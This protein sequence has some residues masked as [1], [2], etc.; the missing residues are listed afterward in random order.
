MVVLW[1]A[2]NSTP[3]EPYLRCVRARA[4]NLMMPYAAIL[5]VISEFVDQEDE[6]HIISHPD[7][8]TSF[9]EL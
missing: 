7:M 4:Q 9:T 8:P 1:D 3:L 6:P 5:P 2:K